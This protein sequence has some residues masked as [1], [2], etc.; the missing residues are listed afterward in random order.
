M[1]RANA[2]ANTTSGLKDTEENHGSKDVEMV[3]YVYDDDDHIP[4][5]DTLRGNLR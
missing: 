2:W 5:R 4:W 3:V 1:A